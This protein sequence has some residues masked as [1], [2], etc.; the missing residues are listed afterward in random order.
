MRLQLSWNRLRNGLGG[1]SWA[2][3]RRWSHGVGSRTIECLE[4]R[5]LLASTF[6][7]S[8]PFIINGTPTSLYPAVGIV[9]DADDG[10]CSGTL[11]SSRFVLTAAHCAVG[12]GPTDG[13]FTVGNQI[14]VTSRVFV[15]PNY[16]PALLG[17]DLANDIAIFELNRPVL[18]VAAY[19]LLRTAPTVGQLLTLVGFG[20]GGT[21]TSG[22]TG[23]FGT[24]RVGTVR[25]D[26]VS[27]TLISWF[28]DNNSESNTAPGDSGGPALVTVDNRTFIAGVTS[29]GT[30]QDA[31]LGDHSF[32]TRVDPYAAWIDRIV[33]IAP[34]TESNDDHINFANRTATT[35]VLNALGGSVISGVLELPGDRDVFQ[36]VV[37]RSGTLVVTQTAARLG[38]GGLDTVLRVLDGSGLPVAENDDA[39]NGISTNSAVA[40]NVTAGTYFLSAGSYLEQWIILHVEIGS[41][42]TVARALKP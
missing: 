7:P 16:S 22:T 39:P 1:R 8:A 20:G 30:V 35:L 17:T 5:S 32:D 37:P 12:L 27:P 40:I 3:R 10:H 33:R 18:G 41:F 38:T 25:I 2:A 14:Y 4:Q 13:R 28:F 23:D 26:E 36:V 24:N 42:A 34:L 15:H 9:G 19:P 29:G 21:G 11:I 31:G 6:D